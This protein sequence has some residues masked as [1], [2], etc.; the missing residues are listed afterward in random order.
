MTRSVGIEIEFAGI[1][2]ALASEL[3]GVE[4][5]VE[6][7]IVSPHEH[8]FATAHGDFR[9]E[10]D[11]ELLKRLSRE[12][13]EAARPD[14]LR[15]VAVGA[16]ELAANLATPLELVSPPLPEDEIERF[17]ALVGVLADNGAHGT[18]ESLIH[19]FGVHFN[20]Q[21]SVDPELIAAHVRAFACLFD[22][23]KK[24]DD[25]DLTRALSAWAKP[26]PTDYE[27]CI[28]PAGYAPDAAALIEDY[29]AFN[30]SRNRALDL[31]PL[32]CEL[33]DERVR[34]A[35]DDA[36][37][38]ARPTYHY[39]LPN[40][41]L[42]RGDWCVLDPWQDWLEVER[43]AADRARLERLCAARLAFLENNVLVRDNDDWIAACQDSVEGR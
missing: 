12:D 31:L 28:L 18:G 26:Y 29:L 7:E 5:G 34:A 22:W 19:A 21:A 11:F 41:H 16:L 24:R 15:R 36:R 17:D 3:V 4:L 9:L 8:A 2:F 35:V 38:K 39:R 30:A 25:T 23:L 1:D 14:L 32:L 33:D 42:G 20:P 27:R 13:H 43:L 37:V 10:V 40:S 6:P